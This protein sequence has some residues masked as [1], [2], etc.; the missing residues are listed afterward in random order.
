MDVITTEA[1][2]T[3]VG[4]KFC[5]PIHRHREFRFRSMFDLRLRFRVLLK[6]ALSSGLGSSFTYIKQRSA[7]A[8]LTILGQVSI[9]HGFQTMT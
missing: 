2:A 9:T 3:L 4:R 1:K 5:L 7:E 8:L 6:S